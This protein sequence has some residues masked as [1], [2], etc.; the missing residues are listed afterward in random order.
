MIR[1]FKWARLDD[2]VQELV[3]EFGETLVSEKV[4]ALCAQRCRNLLKTLHR[5]FDAIR[6]EQA[7]KAK[8]RA[9][10]EARFVPTSTLADRSS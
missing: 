8:K 6:V 7:K 9:R 4:E 2:A 1:R 3:S 10:W 5:T